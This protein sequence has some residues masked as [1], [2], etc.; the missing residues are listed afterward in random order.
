MDASRTNH[1]TFDQYDGYLTLQDL[2]RECRLSGA[3]FFAL[4]ISGRI[5]SV[6][7]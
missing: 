2:E 7:A 1:S 3:D 6:P 5:V 4:L